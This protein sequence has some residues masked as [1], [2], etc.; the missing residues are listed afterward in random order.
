MSPRLGIGLSPYTAIPGRTMSN[1]KS[2]RVIA[3]GELDRCATSKVT[4]RLFASAII[5]VNRWA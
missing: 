2:G 1:R 5:A 3:A 4:P